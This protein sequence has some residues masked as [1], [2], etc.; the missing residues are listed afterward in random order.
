MLCAMLWQKQKQKQKAKAKAKWQN[1][2][3]YHHHHHHH[4]RKKPL[5]CIAS[6][7]KRSARS[8]GY[9]A[10]FVHPPH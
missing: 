6:L 3:Y 9:F 5:F 1:T 8:A 4:H 2:F 7:P 10:L